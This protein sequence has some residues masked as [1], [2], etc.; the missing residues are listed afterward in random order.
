M[1]DNKSGARSRSRARGRARQR[2]VQALYQWQIAGQSASE[3]TAQFRDSPEHE[4]ADDEYFGTI[5]AEVLRAHEELDEELA[6]YL[7]RPADQ[8]DPVERAVLLMGLCELKTR[9]DIP[10]RVVLNEGVTLARRFGAQDGQKFV[11]AVLDKAAERWRSVERKAAGR[12]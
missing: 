2:I 11:N 5:L 9:I 1:A 12:T 4:G 3:I 8:L 6:T 7:D 10:Y